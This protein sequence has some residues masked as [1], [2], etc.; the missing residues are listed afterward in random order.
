[1]RALA[2][3]CVMAA[4]TPSLPPGDIPLRNPTVPIGAIQRFDL[5]LFSG[6]WIVR[7][8][9][10]GDWPISAFTVGGTQWRE[11][12]G[13]AAATA[14]ITQRATGV[15]RLSYPDGGARDVW[16][17][18]IDPDHQTVA[19]GS[20]DGAFGLI[21]TRQGTQRADQIAAARNVLD[22]NGYRTDTWKGD[23]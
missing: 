15:L 12:T 9:A 7:E 19:L 5:A 23:T 2:A 4:C 3:L 14:D 11:R 1:M 22:F 16:V 18:W 6:D 10:G 20:P 17:L 13:T 8:S 21:A